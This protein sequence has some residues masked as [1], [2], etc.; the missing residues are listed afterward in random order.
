MLLLMM[1]LYRDVED[2]EFEIHG[3]IIGQN[4]G[5]SSWTASR[6]RVSRKVIRLDS[7]RFLPIGC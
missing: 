4:T 6:S 2:S 3:L 7:A 5:K 1:F